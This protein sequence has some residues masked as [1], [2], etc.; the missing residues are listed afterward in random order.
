MELGHHETKPFRKRL[1]LSVEENKSKTKGVRLSG[2][3]AQL[4]YHLVKERIIPACAYCL[5]HSITAGTRL[6]GTI[7]GCSKQPV[8][9]SSCPVGYH[10]TGLQVEQ[11]NIISGNSILNYPLPSPAHHPGPLELHWNMG[12]ELDPALEP[13]YHTLGGSDY[14]M[15]DY[16][17]SGSEYV[18]PLP[19]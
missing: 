13:N 7:E 2:D 3:I 6:G 8:P 19:P 15:A 16:N 14:A 1:E 4:F 17:V 9:T 10:N 12:F 11:L 5:R 18:L